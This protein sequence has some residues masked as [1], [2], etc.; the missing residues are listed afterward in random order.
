MKSKIVFLQ[1]LYRIKL[2]NILKTGIDFAAKLFGP[3]KKRFFFD[4]YQTPVIFECLQNEFE[5]I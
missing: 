1:L 4:Q 5:I 2:F 3:K